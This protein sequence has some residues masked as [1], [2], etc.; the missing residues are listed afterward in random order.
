MSDADE[1]PVRIT[2]DAERCVGHA[3]CAVVAPQIY[4]LNDE[5]YNNT[6]E[7]V[8]DG[9]LAALARRGAR[10]CPEGVITVQP[11]NASTSEEK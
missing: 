7:T 4:K 9:S 6:P 5:G 1:G 10:S 11:V 2:V 3:R 8:V